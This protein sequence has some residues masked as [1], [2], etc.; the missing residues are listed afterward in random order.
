VAQGA[1]HER[2]LE[3]IGAHL[4]R[5]EDAGAVAQLALAWAARCDPPLP[6]EEVRRILDDLAAKEKAKLRGPGPWEAPLPFEDPGLPPF[7][8]QELPGWLGDFVRAEA[9]ATQ[10]PPDLPAMLALSVVAAACARRVEVAVK[11]GYAEPVNV[12]TVVALAP[13]NRKSAVFTDVTEPLTAFEQA[14]ATL[15]KPQIAT[16]TNQRAIREARLTRLQGEAAKA[17]PQEFPGI[18]QEADA[19]ARELAD[20]VIPAAPRLVAAD[21]TPEKLVSLLREHGGRMAVLSPEGDVF[22]LMAGRYGG[23]GPPNFGVYLNGHAGDD[24]RVDRV[25]RP[26]EFVKKP[27]LTLGL[28][29]Q[30][31]VIR[32]LAD[33]PGFRGRGLLGRFL[34]SLPPS[35]VG[36]RQVDPPPV[37]PC[38]RARY[39]ERVEALLGLLPGTDAHG[40]PQAH[41][42]QLSEPAL[43]RWLAFAG[44]VEQQLGEYGELGH[45]ADWA[46]KLPGAVARVAGLLHLAEHAGE[47]APPWGAPVAAETMDRAVAVG[48]YLI[49]HARAAFA[50]MG[51]DPVV[52]DARHVLGWLRRRGAPALTRRAIFEGV[53]GRFQR[54]DNLVPALA[55]LVAHGYLCERPADDRPGPG[56]RPSP[57]YD[58]N[59]AA[60]VHDAPDGQDPEPPVDSANCANTATNAPPG[61]DPAPA[62]HSGHSVFIPTAKPT[63]RDAT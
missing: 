33:R 24:L 41:P 57:T 28:A 36:R 1:R 45:V 63:G 43:A 25:G 37:P 50:C 10:T 29:V 53:K 62:G 60:L 39:R 54:V 16:A 46:G 32:G 17:S 3:L 19:L 51:T 9:E 18:L 47:P 55:L 5:G 56:R 12:S 58:V 35:L 7:P 38:V 13:G 40:N 30:P 59:P 11:P 42:L 21:T 61:A 48:R 44:W 2:A 8:V 26:P 4:G 22:D 31:D 14:Q 27:A 49:P 34:Y 52:E 23:K 20:L 6:E 15:L